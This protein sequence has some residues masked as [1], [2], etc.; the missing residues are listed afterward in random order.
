MDTPV[1]R[2]FYKLWLILICLSLR[3]EI[4][5]YKIDSRQVKFWGKRGKNCKRPLPRAVK[6][7]KTLRK[8]I[9]MKE[10]SRD[11]NLDWENLDN[12]NLDIHLDN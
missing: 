11:E 8:K 1:F 2:P 9:E 5:F 4:S 6:T 12:G 10:M 7:S 3:D